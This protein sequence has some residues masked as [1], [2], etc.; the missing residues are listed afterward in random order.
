MLARVEGGL[1]VK[2]MEMENHCL[3][4][5][6]VHKVFTGASVPWCNWLLCEVTP[7]LE[8]G[9][10]ATSFLGHLVNEELERYCSLT[11]V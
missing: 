4:L 3:L 6:F 8:S 9:I 7:D 11:W 1:G 10:R 5:K 2:N